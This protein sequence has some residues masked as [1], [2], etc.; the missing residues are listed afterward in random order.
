MLQIATQAAKAAGKILK[1]G[2]LKS[3]V[4]DFSYKDS[5]KI[6]TQYDKQAE[7][8]IIN[9]I[10]R[11]YP[12]HAILAEE[13]G[14]SAANSDY[15]WIIDPLDGTSNFSHHIPYFAV[16][17]SL[18]Y[19][20][21]P[22]LSVIYL[23]MNDELFTAQQGKGAFLN[24]QSLTISHNADLAKAFIALNRGQNTAEKKR[25]GRICSIM[26]TQVRSYRCTGSIATDLCYV[27]SGRFDAQIINGCA[28][29]DIAGGVLLVKEAG[30]VNL[31]FHGQAYSWQE[32]LAD[33]ETNDL[34]VGSAK[35]AKKLQLLI[36]G[37]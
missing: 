15:L 21:S 3:G 30:G 14:L 18:F 31:N 20:N 28:I 11:T 8:I 4:I 36:K 34:I 13:T 29:H 26:T 27:A 17:I 32:N 33:D 22:Y 24:G 7:E 2:F 23:P 37:I 25:Y 16:S 19:Q 5:H 10:K 35:L 6:V 12:N 9:T 1:Q